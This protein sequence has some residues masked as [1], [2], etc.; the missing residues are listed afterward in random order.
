MNGQ[1]QYKIHVGEYATQ[2]DWSEVIARIRAVVPRIADFVEESRLEHVEFSL[3]RKFNM[4]Q[5]L[6]LQK[7]LS[8]CGL[9][10][11]LVPEMDEIGDEPAA[12]SQALASALTNFSRFLAFSAWQP[13]AVRSEAFPRYLH[14]VYGIGFRL[15]GALIAVPGAAALMG[16][17]RSFTVLL[18]IVYA[19][20]LW[21]SDCF[22]LWLGL[23]LFVPK[24]AKHTIEIESLL[25]PT[26][27]LEVFPFV[28]TIIG[29]FWR[30]G[31]RLHAILTLAGT[32]DTIRGSVV[33]AI[34]LPW[35]FLG[36]LIGVSLFSILLMIQ[37]M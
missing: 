33:Y 28:G 27:M 11:T 17:S 8:G 12:R 1:V 15:I 25:A 16:D 22:L 29:G 24:L 9:Q 3:P 10:T 5:A 36:M 34:V 13:E 20:S 7:M 35:L 23:R 4:E 32:E 19:S 6:R 21:L 37:V 26:Y 30:M 14:I 18:P 2:E 31:L